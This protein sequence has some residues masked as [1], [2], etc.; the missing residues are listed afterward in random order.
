MTPAEPGAG[1]SRRRL[2]IG[3]GVAGAGGLAALGADYA[4]RRARASGTDESPSLNGEIRIPFYGAHQSGITVEPQAHATYVALNLK[5][6]VAK[7]DLARMLKTITDDAARLTQGVPALADSEP[8]LGTVPARMTVT[9]GFGPNLVARV[10]GDAA[11]PEWLGSLPE[12]GIDQLEDRW[13]DGDLLLQF[14]A[15]DPFTIAHAVRMLLKDTRSSADVR[16]VQRG[17]RRAQGSEKSGTT[18]RNLFGQVDGTVN[19]QPDDTDFK[20]LV[21]NRD[22]WM[23]GGTSMV[24]RRIAM[25]LDKWDRLDRPGR[26]QSVGRNLANGAP[27]TGVNEHDEPDFT[28]LTPVGFPVIPEFS[29]M[30]RARTP[31]RSQRIHRRAYNYD[32]A[33]EPGKISNSGLLFVSYQAD[34]TAQFVPIQQRLDELDLLNEWTT[35]IGSAVFA[36]PPGCD[37]NG[38]IGDTLFD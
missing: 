31:D 30:A 34:A 10:A 16:W 19:P 1:W 3:G 18:M 14:N 38:F 5:K 9:F 25:N 20:E 21:W 6:G 8:E 15:D 28:A 37:E 23:T 2:L 17:F 12:F 4:S 27:L 33:P 32:D 24:I 36:I 26:E 29:H 11:L 13:C 22:G 35:P 7:K